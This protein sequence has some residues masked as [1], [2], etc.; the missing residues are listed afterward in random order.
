MLIFNICF[1]FFYFNYSK[2]P[3]SSFFK[4]FTQRENVPKKL[5]TYEVTQII[6]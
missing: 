2:I 3:F 5:I 4:L 6:I 1:C